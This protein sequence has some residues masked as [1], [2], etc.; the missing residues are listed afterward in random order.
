[1]LWFNFSYISTYLTYYSP[2]P[3]A[4]VQV[5]GVNPG[6]GAILLDE[7]SCSGEEISLLECTTRPV[8]LHHCDHSMDVGVRCQ[9]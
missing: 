1:M 8:G 4:V 5:T 2:F 7:L 3:D 9:G 6:S